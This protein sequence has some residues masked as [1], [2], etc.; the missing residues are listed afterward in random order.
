MSTNEDYEFPDYAPNWQGEVD[1]DEETGWM[2]NE[3][4]V[5]AYPPDF[6]IDE[7]HGT[8]WGHMVQTMR[9]LQERHQHSG[10]FSTKEVT[11]ELNRIQTMEALKSLEAKG[12][13][14]FV[15][16]DSYKLTPLGE[17]LAKHMRDNGAS[18][19]G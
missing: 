7:E 1:G 8:C 11:D 15:G 18:S 4:M 6:I 2:L 9:N 16:P 3:E 17:E 10:P 19:S 5:N 13:I 14:E 12:L